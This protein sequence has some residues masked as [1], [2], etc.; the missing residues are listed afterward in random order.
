MRRHRTLIISTSILFL[1]I[2]T[3][4][5]WE[6][7]LG[8]W[9]MLLVLLYAISFLTLF[10]YLIRQLL[11]VIGERF[12]NKARIYLIIIMALLLGLIIARPNGIIDYEKLGSKDLFIAWQEGV[13]NCTTTLKLKEN[14]QFYL[15]SICFG[16]DKNWGTYSIKSDTI[17][18]K[19]SRFSFDEKHFE[20]GIY[21]ADDRPHGGII[22]EIR[23]YRSIKDTLPYP[24]VVYKNELIK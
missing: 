11:R 7:M 2:N 5:F 16:D 12:R 21:K 15:R 9:N 23:L 24:L 1:L 17:K 19:F 6:G 10:V 13:A 22:G 4:Y 14:G 20:F 8:G 18:L 3:G